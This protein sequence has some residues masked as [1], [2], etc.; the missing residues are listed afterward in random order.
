MQLAYVRLSRGT[1]GKQLLENRKDVCE[2]WVKPKVTQQPGFPFTNKWGVRKVSS[3]G[4]QVKGNNFRS[5]CKHCAETKI[6]LST[7][8]LIL[9]HFPVVISFCKVIELDLPKK[10]SFRKRLKM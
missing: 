5:S 2:M 7:Q 9:T 1:N 4:F 8:D 6:A 10:K 3:R